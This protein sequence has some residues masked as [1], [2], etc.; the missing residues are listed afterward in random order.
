MLPVQIPSPR[1][2]MIDRMHEIWGQTPN[3]ENRV[4]YNFTNFSD[5]LT[6]LQYNLKGVFFNLVGF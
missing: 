1:C 6:D 3:S 4:R 2:I 5:N